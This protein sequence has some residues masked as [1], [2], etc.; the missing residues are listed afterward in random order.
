MKIQQQKPINK[1]EIKR[2]NKYANGYKDK[3]LKNRA[4]QQIKTKMKKAST[5]VNVLGLTEI[6]I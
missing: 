5:K 1:K 3:T 2:N 6:D 4:I